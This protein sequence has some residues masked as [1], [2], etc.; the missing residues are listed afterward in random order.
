MFEATGWARRRTHVRLNIFPDGGVARL[1]VRGDV[2]PDPAHLAAFYRGP[3][4]GA[5][6]GGDVVD[7]S[8]HYY[9]S[10]RNAISPGLPRGHGFRLGDQAGAGSQG[11][12]WLIVR[13]AAARGGAAG[14]DR[15]ALNYIGNAPRG[16]VAVGPSTRALQAPLSWTLSCSPV[17]RCCRRTP[18]QPD[19]DHRFLIDGGAATH[20]RLDIFPDGGV[21]RLRLFG[22]LTDDG[23]A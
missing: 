21:A 9:S 12:N 18:L 8:D 5:E 3:G 17:V 14:R 2:V 19:T 16:R 4:R 15:H 10:P 6:L 11:N 7:C 13:L 22:S 20:V 23:L 1:R